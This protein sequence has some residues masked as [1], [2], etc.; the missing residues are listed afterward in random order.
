MRQ[1]GFLLLCLLVLAGFVAAQGGDLEERVSRLESQ[2]VAIDRAVGEAADET[3]SPSDLR[4]YWKEALRIETVDGAFKFRIGGRMHNDWI[5]VLRDGDERPSNRM[6]QSLGSIDEPNTRVL[7]RRARLYLSGTIYEDLDFAF[8]YDF[9]GGDGA[10]KDVYLALKNIPVVGRVQ[11]GQFKEPFSLEELTSSNHITFMERSVANAFV[12]SRSTGL[13]ISSHFEKIVTWAAGVFRDSDDWGDDDYS[14]QDGS[15]WAFTARATVCPV[16]DDEGKIVV[17][18]GLAA[19][20]RNPNDDEV[21]ISSRPEIRS[22]YS[23]VDTRLRYGPGPGDFWDVTAEAVNLV[24]AEAAVVLGP[25][26]AQAEYILAVIDEHQVHSTNPRYYGWY[27][28]A[29][30]FVTGESRRYNGEKGAFDRVRPRRSLGEDG[31]FGAIELAA[32]VSQIDLNDRA[33]PWDGGKMLSFTLGANWYLNPNARVMLN[34]VRADRDRAEPS[35]FF[36]VRFQ[37]DF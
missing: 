25:F 17:H 26:S 32:R 34:W 12:P 15:D 13:M 33:M 21:R 1:T 18:L 36:G 14:E 7:F 29:S 35:G 22:K 31:G 9:A 30:G 3:A 8:Q 4:V 6:S 23:A 11:V 20:H 19:S 16:Q 37:V 10:F 2:L 5:F 28:Q 27:V 24:G